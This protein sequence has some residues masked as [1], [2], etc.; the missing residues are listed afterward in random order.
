M[1]QQN[2][3]T[4]A[5]VMDPNKMVSDAA[6]ELSSDVGRYGE[7]VIIFGTDK[8]R[9]EAL[10]NKV[11]SSL[12]SFNANILDTVVI[13]DSE[14]YLEFESSKYGGTSTFQ[15]SGITGEIDFS[16]DNPIDFD[17]PFPVFMPSQKIEDAL[18][19]IN[20]NHNPEITPTELFEL[21]NSDKSYKNQIY[22]LAAA[23]AMRNNVAEDSNDWNILSKIVFGSEW[24][25]KKQKI[26]DPFRYH[27]DTPF[28]YHFTSARNLS[29]IL[30]H[31][32]KFELL[33]RSL[34]GNRLVNDEFAGEIFVNPRK[35]ASQYQEYEKALADYDNKSRDFVRKVLSIENVNPLLELFGLKVDELSNYAN[36]K[37]DSIAIDAR[38]ASGLESLSN[39]KIGKQPR[40][41]DYIK[42]FSSIDEVKSR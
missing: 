32:P 41:Y 1:N 23:K 37:I 21:A 27:K 12:S 38:G 3:I 9:V 11:S 42:Y 10:K 34:K 19:A 28:L 2:K 8:T 31:L 39:E 4:Y 18:F 33:G 26:Q 20:P 40:A 14:E 24:D 17:K 5:A 6:R 25:G 29:S 22:T 30:G 15:K 36:R 7:A 35:A 16:L 13:T